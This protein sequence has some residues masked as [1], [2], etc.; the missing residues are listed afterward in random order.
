MGAFPGNEQLQNHQLALTPKMVEELKILQMSNMD[1]LQFIDEQLVENPLLEM[2]E[3]GET[4]DGELDDVNSDENEYEVGYRRAHT[5][6]ENRDFTEY[7]SVP[8]S[9]KEHLIS[10]IGELRISHTCRILALYLI[11]YIDDNGYITTGLD[12]ISQKIKVSADA[13]KTALKVVQDLEPV[14]IGARNLKECLLIQLNKKGLVDENIKKIIVKHLKLLGERK[15]KDLSQI[16]GLSQ[17]QVIDIHNV[18]KKLNVKPG[19]AFNTGDGCRYIIPEL[20]VREIDHRFEVY[21]V[22][23][24]VLNLRISDAYKRMLAGGQSSKDTKRFIRERLTKGKELI[25]AIEQRERTILKVANYIMEYQHEFLRHRYKYL[26]PLTM[27][28]AADSLGLH[29]STISRTVN[30]K[31]IQTP[32]GAFELKFFFSSGFDSKTASDISGNAIKKLIK[33]IIQKED[34]KHPYSDESIKKLLWDEGIDV[35]RRTI[36]KY[37]IDLNIPSAKLRRSI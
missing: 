31:Y 22:N 7:T 35:A 24:C 12:T 37:R 10:Q 16:T 27:K 18:I 2:D 4:V 33:A 14:G 23:G 15:Y 1:L 20:E 25:N 17:E 36:A 3:E 8:T 26:K 32:W 5:V 21:F 13:L 28:M 11:E 6:S 29:E 9:L 34:K 30:Q 19:Q